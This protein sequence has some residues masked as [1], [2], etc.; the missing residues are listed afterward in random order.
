MYCL[1]ERH[2]FFSAQDVYFI[3]STPFQRSLSR[4][5]HEGKIFLWGRV[6]LFTSDSIH[7]F[8]QQ[9]FIEHF[10]WDF[11]E[12]NN[13]SYMVSGRGSGVLPLLNLIYTYIHTPIILFPCYRWGYYFLRQ[14]SNKYVYLRT[15]VKGRQ[16]KWYYLYL[17]WGRFSEV[18]KK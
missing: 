13:K 5:D 7:L 12:I 18:T 4:S 9:N 16:N 15:L 17:N 2:V 10:G 11:A 1:F 14:V 3:L 6:I 8:Y